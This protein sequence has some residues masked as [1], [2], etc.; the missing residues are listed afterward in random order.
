MPPLSL[1]LAA[2][3]GRADLS[4][5]RLAPDTRF[6]DFSVAEV[7]DQAREQAE[8]A[9]RQQL[10]QARARLLQR[11]VTADEVQERHFRLEP[12]ALSDAAVARFG[13]KLDEVCLCAALSVV[14]DPRGLLAKH[15][16]L[17]VTKF[18]AIYR[19]AGVRKDT[20][21][22]QRQQCCRRGEARLMSS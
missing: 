7:V 2:Q 16:C 11:A 1:P 20:V 14:W 17:R 8:R 5:G 21:C 12:V 18:L 19:G 4:E 6:R 9:A 13:H 22:T 15:V 3:T 10:L